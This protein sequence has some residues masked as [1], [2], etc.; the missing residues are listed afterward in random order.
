MSTGW[1][2]WNWG[3]ANADSPQ[4]RGLLIHPLPISAAGLPASVRALQMRE[5][6]A[7]QGT[8]K[9]LPRHHRRYGSAVDDQYARLRVRRSRHL[10]RKP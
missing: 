7:D 9:R 6:N 5:E 2:V 8:A 4:Q 10:L 3:E 1:P